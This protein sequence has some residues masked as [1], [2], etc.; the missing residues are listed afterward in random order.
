MKIQNKTIGK[1]ILVPHYKGKTFQFRLYQ[2]TKWILLSSVVVLLLVFGWGYYQYTFYT[3]KL[4]SLLNDNTVTNL[5]MNQISLDGIQI[6][7][8]L[9]RI[10]MESDAMDKFIAQ[11]K[12]FDK[13]AFAGLSLLYS[14]KT[15][16]DFFRNHA[17]AYD[18][19]HPASSSE[20]N[21]SQKDKETILKESIERQKTYRALMDVTP[22]GYPIEGKVL[23]Q[24]SILPKPAVLLRAPAGTPIHATAT[25][26]VLDIQ[27]TD[28]GY[29]IQIVHQNPNN[30]KKIKSCYHFCDKPTV[31]VNQQVK[32]GQVIAYVGIL[33]DSYLSVMGY[34]VQIDRIYIQ[35]K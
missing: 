17:K 22:S 2:S 27:K 16:P 15:F 11:A 3:S 28:H 20:Q 24:Q 29:A 7:R 18:A 12:Q 26:K 33:P 6:K 14:S 30:D 35:P 13:D 10:K 34:Q 32:K 4:L 31:T 19:S 8:E 5:S 23:T 9:I 25:G 21:V 1:I